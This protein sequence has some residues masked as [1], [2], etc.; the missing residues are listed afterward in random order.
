MKINDENRRAV[1]G[2]AVMPSE[3]ARSMVN[4]GASGRCGRDSLSN[5]VHVRFGSLADICT[6]IGHVR[7]GFAEG[8]VKSLGSYRGH[9]P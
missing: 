7:S 1:R 6:A 9:L 2:L 4:F 3:I 5:P 8:V